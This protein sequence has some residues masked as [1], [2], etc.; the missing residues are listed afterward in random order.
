[1]ERTIAG[2]HEVRAFYRNPKK[3]KARHGHLEW[4]RGDVRNATSVERAVEGSEAVISVLG[5]G[6]SNPLH[7]TKPGDPR[8]PGSIGAEHIVAAMRQQGIRRFICQTA[9]GVGESK[10][11]T[12]LAGSF[13]LRVL[14][15]PLLRDDYADKECQEEVVRG[16][17]LD[18]VIVRP[19]ILTNGPWTGAYRAA[20]E[21]HPGRRPYISRADVADFLTHQ[22]ADDAFVRKTPTI[23]Y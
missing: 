20:E 19:L 22:L 11:N 5:G 9:W 7:P 1:M 3:A 17:E 14:V 15:P 23:G 6:P 2:G 18:W 13:F 10:E 16:S 21:L 12:D 8:G 4:I